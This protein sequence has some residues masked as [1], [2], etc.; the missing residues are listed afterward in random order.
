[1]TEQYQQGFPSLPRDEYREG[2][3]ESVNDKAFIDRLYNASPNLNA[4]WLRFGGTDISPE[5][6]TK[7]RAL[8]IDLDEITGRSFLP[9]FGKWKALDAIKPKERAA[10]LELPMAKAA[11]D[12]Q[13]K[14]QQYQ[15]DRQQSLQRD[16][17]QMQFDFQ[18]KAGQQQLQGAK[19]LAEQ[20]GK[21]GLRQSMFNS[22]M[23]RASTPIN[24]LR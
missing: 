19:E 3:L 11:E 1:M 14:L 16:N 6:A 8:G 20:Q 5:D 10:Q 9:S 15:I 12:R 24:W 18:T 13:F 7:A 4:F 21:M 17:A 2:L 22:A 23:Q